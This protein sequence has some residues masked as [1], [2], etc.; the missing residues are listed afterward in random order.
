VDLEKRRPQ[1][2]RGIARVCALVIAAWFLALVGKWL[3]EKADLARRK[4]RMGVR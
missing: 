4:R 2:P 3:W 1:R